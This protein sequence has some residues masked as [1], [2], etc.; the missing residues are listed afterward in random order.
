M[1]AVCGNGLSHEPHI[2]DI[3]SGNV[4]VCDTCGAFNFASAFFCARCGKQLGAAARNAAPAVASAAVIPETPEKFFGG[5]TAD[6]DGGADVNRPVSGAVIP[7]FMPVPRQESLLEKLDRMEKELEENRRNEPAPET[8]AKGP[9]KLDEHEESLKKIAYTL[10]SLIA[11]L[12]EAEVRE[13]TF[14]DFVH[15]DGSGFPSK[16]AAAAAPVITKKGR[17]LQ[18][19]LVIIALIAAIFLLGL[20][21]GLWGS[22]FFG[23]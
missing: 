20:T 17:N 15:P 5:D 16:D 4:V 13:Y 19:I 8:P 11:D 9:D 12:L 6:G 14:P 10:D 21:F 3:S 23:I 2:S 1:C 18:E 7:A 22:F